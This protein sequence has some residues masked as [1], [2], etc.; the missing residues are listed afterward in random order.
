MTVTESI[1]NPLEVDKTFHFFIYLVKRVSASDKTKIF[2]VPL[3]LK[4]LLSKK[5]IE[6]RNVEKTESYDKHLI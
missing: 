4:C 3:S 2:G 1:Y 5:T 6:V